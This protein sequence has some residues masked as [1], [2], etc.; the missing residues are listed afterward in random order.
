MHIPSKIILF[1][2]AIILMVMNQSLAGQWAP[3]DVPV[4]TPWAAEVTPDNVLPEYPR[5]QMRRSEWKNLNG[6]WEYSFADNLKN[7]P[8]G[9]ELSGHI[10]VPFAV[11]SALSGVKDS[12]EYLWYRRTFSFPEEWNGQRLLLHFGA[13]DWQTVVYV[14]GNK[15]GEHQGGYDPFTIDITDANTE[16]GS[17]EIIVGVFDPSDQS[18]NPVGKQ[19]LDPSGIWYTSVTGIWQTVWL[20]PVP[21]VYIDDI[22]ISSD[23]DREMVKIRVATNKRS[24]SFQI[25]INVVENEKTIAEAD[26]AP[27]E[28]VEI[29]IPQPHLWEPE[30][31][32]LYDLKIELLDDTGKPMDEVTSYFGMREISLGTDEDGITRMLLN[33]EYVFQ[34]GPLDQ[35]YW[36]DGLYTAP[37]DE[38]LRFDIEKAKEFGFN[39]I[40]KHVKVEPARWYYWCD[41][42]GVLVWQ[43][44]PSPNPN[45]YEQF[46]SDE[47]DQQFEYELRQMVQ[48]LSNHPSIVMWVVFNEGWGQHNTEKLTKMVQELDPTRLVNNASGY[49]DKGVGDVIDWHIYPGPDAPAPEERRASVLGEFGGLGLFIDGHTWSSENWGYEDFQDKQQFVKRYEQLFDALWPL[50]KNPGLSAAVYTQTT[51]VETE[52][53]GLLTYDRKVQKL[54]SEELAAYHRD[55]MV[56]PPVIDPDGSLFLDSLRVKLH[57]R[58][59]EVIR[60]TLDGGEPTIQSTRY[61]SPVLITEE[62]TLKAASFGEVDKRSR[63]YA[64]KFQETSLRKSESLQKPEPRLRF[65][66]YEGEWD[67]L[68][69]FSQLHSIETGTT[70]TPDISLTRSEDHFGFTFGGYLKIEQSGVYTFELTSDDGSKLIIGEEEVVRND[71]VHGMRARS[72]QIA[73]EEGFHPL[74][75]EYFETV[76]GHGLV[77]RWSGP[78]FEKQI[79][80]QEFFFHSGK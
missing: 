17:L 35:G 68:P 3:K 67:S 70:P 39:M 29:P 72:G 7:P 48:T 49:T 33:G 61:T 46:R 43:D 75:I 55:T 34:M 73:L 15:V 76:L 52:V 44:M 9:Q 64:A 59:G 23:I 30:D 37:T 28:L 21:D 54:P 63:I 31:P 74:K 19:V 8:F 79:V 41:R 27:G 53:N 38:A 26:G 42:L 40:R 16:S 77:V 50:E 12:T 13:V 47:A 51:D 14:N 65:T 57:N 10:L 11:E 36:P 22:N 32:F 20:E 45:T 25:R 78:G 5:P 71:G 80:P 56:S 62:T 1:S 66:H 4:M 60:Y 6:L 18:A 69:D 2:L 24:P 58:K